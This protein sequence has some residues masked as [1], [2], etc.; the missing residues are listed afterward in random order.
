VAEPLRVLLVDDSEADAALLLHELRNGGYDVTGERV[1]TAAAMQ[2]AL[3]SGTWDVVLADYSMP[4]FTALDALD[5]LRNSGPDVPLII[6]SGT[7][8][9]ETA[10][11]ALKA[12]ACDFVVKGRLARLIPA[13]ERG[14]R[15]AG[16]RR[17]RDHAQQ[18]L[19]DRLR[20][21]EKMEAIGQLAGGV[22]H[23]F[24]N[25][26][27]AILGYAELITQQIGPDKPI[28]K[29]LQEIVAAGQ[30]AA[31]LTRQ[32]LAFSRK[33]SSHPVALSLNTV[34]ES[35]EPMLRRLIDANVRIETSLDPDT[36]TVLADAIQ[37]EQVLMNLAVNARDAMPTGG[38]L[39]IETGNSTLRHEDVR[40]YRG[41][42]PGEYAVLRV[43][44]TGVG[45]PPE[46]QA[47]IFEPF[48]TT[49][50]RGRGTGLGLAAVYGITKQLNGYIAVDSEIGRG[51]AF[52]IY[53]P[54]TNG[55]PNR[56]ADSGRAAATVGTE[57]ILLVEDELG[58]RSF[59]KTVLMRHGY[60]VMDEESS[61]AALARLERYS[62]AL[63]LLVTDVM[64]AGADGGT[65]ARHLRR[66]H[67]DLRVLFMSGYTDPKIKRALPDGS[68][69]EKPFTA[70]GLLASVRDT[71]A[72]ARMVT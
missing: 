47:H 27:T 9:E 13:I 66:S 22:A 64:L 23:D 17:D 4:D 5:V 37:L 18:L 71:L 41:A 49:K 15:E 29:D 38:M 39:T 7:I 36:H 45:M 30:R 60:R 35:L 69:L 28:G 33:Q 67:P 11:T 8:G 62:G 51:T 59:A 63:D 55:T 58:V 25:M 53:L 12:G 52:T 46:V 57:V 54:R 6:V 21:A 1:Q 10:V 61:E 72:T 50:E 2:A 31:A 26:L 43:S 20:Q 34:V 70:H 19:E 42:V 40:R 3:E 32:L 56:R 24:N 44:D 48:F 65:L 14:R 16:V 68:F